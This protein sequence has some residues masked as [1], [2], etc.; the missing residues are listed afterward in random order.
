M[1]IFKTHRAPAPDKVTGLDGITSD[2]L[3]IHTKVK[4]MLE[5]IEPPVD[6]RPCP[7]ILMLHLHK[8]ALQ[9]QTAENFRLATIDDL[10]NG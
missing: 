6:G 2:Q 9:E 4:K 10:S 3:L 7:V 8:L 1:W 5:R